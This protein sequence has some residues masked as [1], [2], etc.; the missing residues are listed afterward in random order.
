MLNMLLTVRSSTLIL[1]LCGVG[2]NGPPHVAPAFATNISNLVSIF[3]IS[4]TMD[5]TSGVF[6]KSAGTAIAWPLIP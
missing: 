4:L 2:S 6:D 3:S 1:L 5:S